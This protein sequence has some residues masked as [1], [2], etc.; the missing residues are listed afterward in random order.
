MRPSPY[1]SLAPL[2]RERG[3]LLNLIMRGEATQADHEALGRVR[4]E[5]EEKEA[6]AMRETLDEVRKGAS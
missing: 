3:R 2:Y 1:D 6:A 4:A 5:L